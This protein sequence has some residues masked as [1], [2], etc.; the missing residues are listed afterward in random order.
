MDPNIFI[1]DI[2]AR[3]SSSIDTTI[4][5][6]NVLARHRRCSICFSIELCC[7]FVVILVDHY[8]DA[9]SIRIS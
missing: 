3:R 1:I 6:N 5:K 8:D 2:S 4:I 7:C 9:A